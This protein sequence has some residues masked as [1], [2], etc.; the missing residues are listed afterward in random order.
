MA[1]LAWELPRRNPMR[2]RRDKRA[3]TTEGTEI[4]LGSAEWNERFLAIILYP[5]GKE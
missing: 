1:A 5:K 2:S 3:S 4:T